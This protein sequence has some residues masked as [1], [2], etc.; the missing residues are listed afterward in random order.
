MVIPAKLGVD[1]VLWWGNRATLLNN[2]GR[3]G[4]M[5]VC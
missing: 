5:T 2:P 1:Y 3:N 4:K